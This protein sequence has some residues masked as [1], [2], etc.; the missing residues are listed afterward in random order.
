[1][2]IFKTCTIKIFASNNNGM[3][4]D[5]A[6]SKTFEK[7]PRLSS[8]NGITHLSVSMGEKSSFC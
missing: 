5:F 7:H 2:Y 3:C 6:G 4:S 1:M 8:N